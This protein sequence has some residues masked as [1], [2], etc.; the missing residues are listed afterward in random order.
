MTQPE[1]RLERFGRALVAAALGL[2]VLVVLLGLWRGLPLSE[3]LMVAISQMVL[4]VPEGL[5]VAMT[6]APAVGMQR[7]AVTAAAMS[8]GWFARRLQ[9]GV[10]LALART[11]L[12]TRVAVTQWFKVLNCQSAHASALG[13]ASWA[14]AGCWAAGAVGAAGA[15]DLRAAHECAVPHHAAGAGLAAV[16]AAAG[17]R[18]GSK[19]HASHGCAGPG[20]AWHEALPVAGEGGCHRAREH[21]A[22]AVTLAW[23]LLQFTVCAALIAREGHLLS[24]RADALAEDHG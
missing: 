3:V 4:I 13:R 11:G 18:C 19:R 20:R 24:R 14:T 9:Q 15:V 2:F 8:F 23:L 22:D 17:Q 10:D 12:F 1:L 16:A 7:M 6:I 5:S 21:G